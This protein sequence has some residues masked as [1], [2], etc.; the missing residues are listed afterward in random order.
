MADVA[1]L[2][3]WP[4]SRAAQDIHGKFMGRLAVTPEARGQ[5][6]SPATVEVC[7]RAKDSRAVDAF[8]STYADDAAH[9]AYESEW[10]RSLCGRPHLD[11]WG[12]VPRSVASFLSWHAEAVVHRGKACR[13][14][15]SAKFILAPAEDPPHDSA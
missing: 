6:A 15:Q 3:P 5:D 10:L 14:R 12:K 9:V 8:E 2:L 13:R 4:T 7:R 11:P 1:P